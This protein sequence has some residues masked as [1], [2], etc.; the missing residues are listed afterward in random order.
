[1]V[2][3]SSVGTDRSLIPSAEQTLLLEYSLKNV[4]VWI[5]TRSLAPTVVTVEPSGEPLYQSCHVSL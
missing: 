1:M 4:R 3:L 2:A 5:C